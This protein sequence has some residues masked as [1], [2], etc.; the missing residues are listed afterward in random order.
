MDEQ[1]M[2][3]AQARQALAGGKNDTAREI[4]RLESRL[5]SLEERLEGMTIVGTGFSGVGPNG[6]RFNQHQLSITKGATGATGGVG[7]TGA[8]GDPSTIAGPPGETGA[9]GA[10]GVT[11]PTG[12]TGAT[13]ATGA[14]GT[15]GNGYNYEGP[16][17]GI[18]VSNGFVV[19]VFS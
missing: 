1:G 7:A 4:Q 16:C 13:G 10:T 11:G 19:A 2:N 9:T 8:T 3:R 5:A 18:A 15:G 14:D 17:S 6:I 12:E